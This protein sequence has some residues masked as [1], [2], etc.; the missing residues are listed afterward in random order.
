MCNREIASA[1]CSD[2]NSPRLISQLLNLSARHNPVPNMMLVCRVLCN[3]FDCNEDL[4]VGLRDELITAMMNCAESYPTNQK[5]LVAVSTLL[6]NYAVALHTSKDLQGKTQCVS[7]I[8]TLLQFKPDHEPVFRLLIAL[9]TVIWDDADAIAFAKSVNI[10]QLILV[11]VHVQ[12]PAKVGE[13][14]RLI[15]NCLK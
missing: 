13:C 1:L 4:L 14:A 5:I 8:A 15:V 6:L 12:D 9:G 7:A 11:Y 3:I 2:K 10:E